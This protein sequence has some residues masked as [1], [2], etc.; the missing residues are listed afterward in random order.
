MEEK[1]LPQKRLISFSKANEDVNRFLQELIDNEEGFN[2]SIYICQL[3]RESKK[4]RE[5]SEDLRRMMM[6][7]QQIGDTQE[8][9][10]IVKEALIEALRETN[11]NVQIKTDDQRIEKEELEDRISQLLNL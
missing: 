7:A 3:V 6:P 11:F 10:A 2:L 1:K 9:K 4:N 5:I 8:L